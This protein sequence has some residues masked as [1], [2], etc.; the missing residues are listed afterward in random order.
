[1]PPPRPQW[2]PVRRRGPAQDQLHRRAAPSERARKSPAAHSRRPL[3]S[4][5]AVVPA[6]ALPPR[7]AP[8]RRARRRRRP[9]AP[10]GPGAP[11]HHSRRSWLGLR[12]AARWRPPWGPRCH[13]QCGRSGIPPPPQARRRA[14]WRH[15]RTPYAGG[16][17]PRHRPLARLA[18]PAQPLA[19]RSAGFAL[20][21]PQRPIDS[22]RRGAEV[23]AQRLRCRRKRD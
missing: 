20:A 17:A 22:T 6:L 3:E 2:P 15:W 4:S 11:I 10:P 8:H 23:A 14:A 5:A 16:A 7:Q 21:L 1:M 18:A 12:A 9:A 13:P 19:P